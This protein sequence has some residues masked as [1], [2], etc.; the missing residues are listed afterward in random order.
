M[1]TETTIGREIVRA[2]MMLTNSQSKVRQEQ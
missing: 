2:V 1:E